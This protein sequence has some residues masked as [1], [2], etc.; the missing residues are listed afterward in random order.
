[1]SLDPRAFEYLKP[2]ERQMFVMQEVREGFAKLADLLQR[3]LPDGAD[4]TYTVRK[5]REVAMWSNVAITR[6][7]NGEPRE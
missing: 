3:S 6:E 1:M 5:L 2:T 4:K 7:Q